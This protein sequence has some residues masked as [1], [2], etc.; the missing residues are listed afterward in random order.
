MPRREV[1]RIG[2]RHEEVGAPHLQRLHL[3]LPKPRKRGFM[4]KGKCIE[5]P[6]SESAFVTL[7]RV[8]HR[9]LASLSENPTCWVLFASDVWESGVHDTWRL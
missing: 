3:D 4:R 2:E 8:P 9:P 1:G 5:L 7:V 6:R